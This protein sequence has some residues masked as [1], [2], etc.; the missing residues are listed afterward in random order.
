MM[1]KSGLNLPVFHKSSRKL[2]EIRN[3]CIQVL[4]CKDVDNHSPYQEGKVR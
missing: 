1:T 3:D 4:N 2:N